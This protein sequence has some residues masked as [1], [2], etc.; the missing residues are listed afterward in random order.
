LDDP[1]AQAQD[2]SHD[3]VVLEPG[4]KVSGAVLSIAAGQISLMTSSGAKA[5][6]LAGAGAIEF[7]RFQGRP[8]PATT[9][10]TRATFV[11][12][13]EVTFELLAWRPD[14]VAGL[15]Q[16]LGKV[17]FDPAAFARLEFRTAEPGKAEE[18]KQ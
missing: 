13:G 18:L 1:A 12:G 15:S 2:P 8:P 16:D 7:A 4:N 10:N 6:P 17:T 5:I 11:Q 3:V 9:A 14:G